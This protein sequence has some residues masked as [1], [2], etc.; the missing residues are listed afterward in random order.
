MGVVLASQTLLGSKSDG[1]AN[2][3]DDLIRKTT[4]MGV[5]FQALLVV[6]ED[7]GG[8]ECRNS[9]KSKGDLFRDTIL[10]EIGIGCDSSSNFSSAELIEETNVLSQTAFE[11]VF[12]NLGRDVLS[13]INETTGRDVHYN[14]LADT[15]VHK[16]QDELNQ[17]VIECAGAQTSVHKVV[18]EDAL[19]VTKDNSHERSSFSFSGSL[20]FGLSW[21]TA[22]CSVEPL[23]LEDDG[24][25]GLLLLV[26]AAVFSDKSAMAIMILLFLDQSEDL[27]GIE[28]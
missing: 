3:A 14:K 6:L 16:V 28:F 17:F 1:V 19:E 4:T 26:A 12:A 13:G 7:K 10:D 18:L 2:R 23:R 15:E 5:S 9:S 11:V 8:D 21:R 24:R 25:E 20:K 22:S 27:T